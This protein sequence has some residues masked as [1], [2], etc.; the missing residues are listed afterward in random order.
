MDKEVILTTLTKVTSTV[1]FVLI[2]KTF[3]KGEKMK[4]I[5]M[6]L[7]VT[8]LAFAVLPFVM[9]AAISRS[10]RSRGMAPGFALV[11]RFIQEAR[12]PD[13]PSVND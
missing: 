2:G 12:W 6:T 3:L 13:E 1:I 8:V 11:H 4:K 10:K 9:L 7:L 5:I